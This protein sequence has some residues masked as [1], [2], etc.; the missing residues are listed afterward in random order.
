MK[1][2]RS[3][4]VQDRLSRSR[5]L[6]PFP[7]KSQASPL[8]LIHTRHPP[9][10]P[11]H[12][13]PWP[14]LPLAFS[15]ENSPPRPSPE[16]APTQIRSSP[17]TCLSTPRTHKRPFSSHTRKR[18]RQVARLTLCPVNVDW[19]VPSPF[20]TPS[21]LPGGT[22]ST[23][24]LVALR[25]QTRRVRSSEP[26]TRDLPSGENATLRRIVVSPERHSCGVSE[27]DGDSLRGDWND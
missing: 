17:S 25:S 8:V 12:L 7:R 24:R 26:D 5:P 14:R 20:S 1:L 21:L 15:A 22:F 6:Q 16:P 4:Q 27:Y 2:D 13:K 3:R 10:P 18:A 9:V 23:A 19:H 11:L